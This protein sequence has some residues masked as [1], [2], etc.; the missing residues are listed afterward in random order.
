MHR[1]RTLLETKVARDARSER[2]H[3]SEHQKVT[4]GQ[5]MSTEDSTDKNVLAEI[6][7][8]SREVQR[9]TSIVE[10]QVA[11]CGED[12]KHAKP[13]D[14]VHKQCQASLQ[15]IKDL[16]LSRRQKQK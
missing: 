10:Q 6:N 2:L 8:L 3:A 16:Y 15:R 5:T 7:R 13:P 1:R 9:L 14:D 4:L 11:P 12:G